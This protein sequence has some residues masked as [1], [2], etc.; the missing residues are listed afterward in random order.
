MKSI[1][2]GVVSAGLRPLHNWHPLVIIAEEGEVEVRAA[3]V[4]LCADGQL[5]QQP[6]HRFGMAAI[7]GIHNSVLKSEA[8]DR[9][10]NISWS[11]IVSFPLQ[12]GLCANSPFIE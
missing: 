7:F 2:D 6:T 11:W 1:P 4:G 12:L 8:A 9:Q 10:L 5:T 3:A